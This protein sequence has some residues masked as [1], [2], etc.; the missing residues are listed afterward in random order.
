MWE[1]KMG[2]G[3]TCNWDFKGWISLTSDFLVFLTLVLIVRALQKPGPGP[4]FH[5]AGERM[6][7]NSCTSKATWLSECFVPLH[8]FL[9]QKGTYGPLFGNFPT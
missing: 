6:W 2:K 5:R 4:R 7:N 9:C 8:T 3:T 1:V